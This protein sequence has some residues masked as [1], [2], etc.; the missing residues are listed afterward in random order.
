M[1]SCEADKKLRTRHEVLHLEIGRSICKAKNA[2][3]I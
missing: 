1:E 2:G 3:Y